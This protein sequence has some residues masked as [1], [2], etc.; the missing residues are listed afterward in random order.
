MA[1]SPPGVT[2]LTGV[3]PRAG[4]GD[5]L[6]PVSDDEFGVPLEDVIVVHGD[7]ATVQYGMGTYGSRTAVGARP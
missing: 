4:P 6:R 1:S 2:V 7:T 5:D 3:S